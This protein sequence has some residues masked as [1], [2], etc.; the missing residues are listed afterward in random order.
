AISRSLSRA[1]RA[2]GRDGRGRLSPRRRAIGWLIAMGFIAYGV[3]PWQRIL[4]RNDAVPA[5]ADSS[6]AGL[7]LQAS[8]LLRRYDRSG[9]VDRAI[10]LLQRATAADA[11]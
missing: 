9:N 10:E 3:V 5:V 7:T 6:P 2:R 8:D 4:H 11:T 1:R